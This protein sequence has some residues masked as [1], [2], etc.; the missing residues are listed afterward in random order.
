MGIGHL[1]SKLKMKRPGDQKPIYPNCSPIVL[2][3]VSVHIIRGSPGNSEFAK[4][5]RY[6]ESQTGGYYFMVCRV[7]Q[8][9]GGLSI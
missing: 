9:G 8:K 1:S 5:T 4:P 3:A 6:G 7:V 2:T